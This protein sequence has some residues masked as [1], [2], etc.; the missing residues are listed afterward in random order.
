MGVTAQLGLVLLNHAGAL[1]GKAILWADTR[2]RGEAQELALALGEEGLS[3]SGRRMAPELVAPRLLWF[4]RYQPEVF[5]QV[6]RI[7][8]IKDFVVE[9]LT[10]AIITDETHASYTGMFDVG[11]RRWSRSLMQRASCNPQ[12]FPPVGPADG[13]AG[14][15]RPSVAAEI[16]I[17]PGVP[18]SI[19]A[20]DGTAGAIGA[21][22][23]RGGV[24]VD[25]AGTTDVVLHSVEQP[26]RD[27]ARKMILNA[28]AAPGTWT[29]GGPTGFTGGAISWAQKLFGVGSPDEMRKALAESLTI[30]PPGSEGLVFHTALTGSRFPGWDGA[31][32][33]SLHGIEVSHG[34]AH[35]LRA[36]QEGA[37]FTVADA[38]DAIRKSG[39]RI[40]EVIVVGGLSTD[41]AA[42][43]LRADAI[44]IPVSTLMTEEASSAGSAMLT[45]VCAKVYPDL[46]AAADR[47][48]RRRDRFE[49]NQ[50]VVE[51]LARARQRWSEA[52]RMPL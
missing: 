9:Q 45:G 23:I 31:E 16:G 4:H 37:A 12:W 29:V 52:G 44:D 20:S 38:V 26:L 15:V 14:G 33:G 24:T 43:Q 7:A 22:A 47:F 41:R 5:S 19:G 21:G 25:V 18:V 13:R 42:V 2:A 40:S 27:P 28:H 3:V 30:V 46:T 32:R 17:A 39:A 1:L 8:S 49:P 11:Q 10:G 51:Q 36:A 34:M 35:I 50:A 6:A 48:V